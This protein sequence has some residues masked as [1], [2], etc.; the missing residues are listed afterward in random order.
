MAAGP[1]LRRLAARIPAIIPRITTINGMNIFGNEPMMGV[2]RAA[3]IDRV[4]I[5]RWTS[6]K[7]VAQ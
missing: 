4:A 7:F 5:A 2:L 3:D 1:E 6:T